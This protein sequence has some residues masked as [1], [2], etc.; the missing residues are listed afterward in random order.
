MISSVHLTLLGPLMVALKHNTLSQRPCLANTPGINELWHVAESHWSSLHTLWHSTLQTL[1]PHMYSKSHIGTLSGH[2]VCCH[3][4][5]GGNKLQSVSGV[6]S[7]FL[8]HVGITALPLL[9]HSLIRFIRNIHINFTLYTF[10]TSGWQHDITHI[11]LW[12]SSSQYSATD[13]L[14]IHWYV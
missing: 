6:G 8:L 1:L 7:F 14:A 9:M 5:K 13:A 12:S 4:T 3:C 2:E 11:S 10:T